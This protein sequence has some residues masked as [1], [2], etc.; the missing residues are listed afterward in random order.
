MFVKLWGL[1]VAALLCKDQWRGVPCMGELRRLGVGSLKDTSMNAKTWI[2]CR[3]YGLLVLVL[4]KTG[5]PP[6]AAGQGATV[7]YL[8]E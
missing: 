3:R 2:H 4:A 7:R 8:P 6:N 1:A 5:T